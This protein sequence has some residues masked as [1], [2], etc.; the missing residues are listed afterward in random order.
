MILSE[1]ISH[2]SLPA[3]EYSEEDALKVKAWKALELIERGMDKDKVYKICRTTSSEVEAYTEDW[4][5]A[6][7]D[8]SF[9]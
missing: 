1:Y 5:M 7:H 9:V 2:Q 3:Y 8:Y 6:K 4:Y